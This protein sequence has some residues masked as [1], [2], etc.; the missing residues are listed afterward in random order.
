MSDAHEQ[1]PHPEDPEDPENPENPEDPEDSENPEDSGDPVQHGQ[2]QQSQDSG[3]PAPYDKNLSPPGAGHPAP[4]GHGGPPGPWASP[5]S[6]NPGPY[7]SPNPYGPPPEDPLLRW[8][9]RTWPGT[10]GGAPVAVLA[11]VVAAGLL[12]ALLIPFHRLG[13]GFFVACC[14]TLGA[15]LPALLAPAARRR[16]ATV[17]RLGLLAGAALLLAVPL[18]R[19]AGWLVA[20]AV[21]GAIGMAS[22]ATTGGRSWTAVLL[23]GGVPPLSGIRML[24]WTVRGVQQVRAPGRRDLIWPVVRTGLISV[25]LLVVFGA[26]FASADPAFAHLVTGAVPDI[27]VGKLIVRA[28]VGCFVAGCALALAF[29]AAAPPRLDTIAP[30]PGRGVRRL[31]WLV[32]VAALDLLFLSF[33]VVQLAVL[34]GGQAYVQSTTGLTYAEY[35]HQGFAQLVVTTVLTLGVL[36]V[37]WRKAPSS[38]RT[39]GWLVRLMLAVLCVLTLVV[40]VSA[41]WRIKLYVGAYG[42]TQLRLVAAGFELWVVVLFLLALL[43]GAPRGRWLP[44]PPGGRWLPRAAVASAAVALLALVALNPDALVARY[45][46]DRFQATGK[47]DIDYLQR[48]SADAAPELNELPEPYRSCALLDVAGYLDEPEPWFAFNVARARARAILPEQ[49]IEVSQKQRE[50]CRKVDPSPAGRFD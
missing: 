49:P 46:I 30:P 45:N 35:V 50:R 36:A 6:G 2:H 31:E 43:A 16:G 9:R 3:H 10:E 15:S 40:A 48:L 41:L 39:D 12:G 44:L 34:F 19:A 32:P 7:G 28:F 20:L 23:A 27:E 17:Y 21:L 38:T 25:G 5:G 1:P 11:T 18:V 37:A 4:Q 42:L 13:L 22:L 8:F 24:P 26:L 14:V 33:V 29:T 47:L